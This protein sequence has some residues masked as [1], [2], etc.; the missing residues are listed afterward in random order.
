MTIQKVVWL[1]V[2]VLVLFF[3]ITDPTTAGHVVGVVLGELRE[4]AE[5]VITFC[6]QAFA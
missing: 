4:A 6:Q 2:A 3:V 5:A 1:V